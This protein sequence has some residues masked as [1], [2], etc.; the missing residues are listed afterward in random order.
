M[1]SHPTDSQHHVSTKT[2]FDTLNLPNE[3]NEPEPT[4]INYAEITSEEDLIR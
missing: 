4:S 2:T 1:K 3:H